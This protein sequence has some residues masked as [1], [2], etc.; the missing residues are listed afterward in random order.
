MIQMSNSNCMYFL[1]DMLQK[2]IACRAICLLLTI[3]TQC[4]KSQ[5]V[6]YYGN[7]FT[8]YYSYYNGWMGDTLICDDN[9]PCIVNCFGFTSCESVT[10]YGPTDSTLTVN[11]DGSRGDDVSGQ[12]CV[13][14]IIHAE[15]CTK[16]YINVYNDNHQAYGL[17]IYTPTT[18]TNPNGINTCITCGIIEAHNK[19]TAL[20]VGNCLE[21]MNI[22]SRTGFSSVEWT[23]SAQSVWA[24]TPPAAQYTDKMHCGTDYLDICSGLA[25]SGRYIQCVDATSPCNAQIDISNYGQCNVQEPTTTEVKTTVSETESSQST[26]TGT[27]SMSTMSEECNVFGFEAE[28]AEDFICDVCFSDKNRMGIKGK[29]V[30]IYKNGKMDFTEFIGDEVSCMFD[31]CAEIND[32]LVNCD[33]KAV[34]LKENWKTLDCGCDMFQCDIVQIYSSDIRKFKVFVAFCVVFVMFSWI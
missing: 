13:R 6:T 7:Q 5:N 3:F 21:S 19:Q 1:V 12:G 34:E 29:C 22:Y 4:N 25:P 18:N 17:S 9:V 24:L 14:T 10:I 31:Y 20:N 15:P 16:L 30:S 33:V 26:M 32:E 11:C 27:V 8:Q 23:Y 28:T 2:Y